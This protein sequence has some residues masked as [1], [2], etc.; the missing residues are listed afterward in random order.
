M[1]DGEPDEVLLTYDEAVALLPDGDRIHT[2]VNPAG[3]LVGADWDRGDVL[4]L[5]RDTDRR[6]VTGPAA[7]AFGHGLAAMHDGRPVFIEA[8]KWGEP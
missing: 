7:Q 3:I 6:E 8:R 2:F 5:L 1:A 4:A